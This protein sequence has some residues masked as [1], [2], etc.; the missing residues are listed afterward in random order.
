MVGRGTMPAPEDDVLG[1][2]LTF[3]AITI[4]VAYAA[5]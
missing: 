4:P 3:G 5:L 2:M 1:M